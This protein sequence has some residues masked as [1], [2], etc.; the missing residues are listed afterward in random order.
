M[1]PVVF[2]N[3]EVRLARS[4][5]EIDLAQALRYRIFYEEM[6]AIPTPRMR[7]TRRDVDPYDSVCDHLLLIDRARNGEIPCVIGTYRMMRKSAANRNAGFYSESEFDLGPLL[8]HPGETLELGRSCI[9]PAYRSRSAMQIMWAGLACY[10]HK[11]N[12]AVL[13]G[14]GSLPGTDIEEARLAL[15]YLHRFHLAPPD[16]CPRALDLRA[17]AIDLLPKDEIDLQAAQ[18]RLPPLIK[19]YL[20]L[21]AM[22]GRG[23]VIDHRFNTVDVCVVLESERLTERYRKHFRPLLSPMLAAANDTRLLAS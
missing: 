2:A 17:A 10:I 3:F 9:D 8:D 16:I 4:D 11:E 15:S 22:I 23:A 7:Q 14:C 21:G 5:F 20:R 1:E 18:R 13:F 6:G 19:G 12:I